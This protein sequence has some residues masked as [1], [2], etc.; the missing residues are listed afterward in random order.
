MLDSVKISQLHLGKV[1]PAQL[2]ML[3]KNSAESGALL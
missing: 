3:L 1:H 2:L